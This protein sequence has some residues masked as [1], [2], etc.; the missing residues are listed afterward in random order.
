MAV[1]DLNDRKA[2]LEALDE[3]DRVG[4]D[5]FL[6]RHGFGRARDY[7][8]QHEGRLYDSK[9]IVGVAHGYQFGTP[10]GADA[11]SGGDAV[12]VPILERLG[13]PV[14]STRPKPG[15]W[16]DSARDVRVPKAVAETEWA[17]AAYPILEEVASRYGAVIYYKD[18]AE[19]I[20]DVSGVR[21]T[22]LLSN[23][24]GAVL[25]K[26]LHRAADEG[27]PPLTALVVRSEDGGVGDGYDESLFRYRGRRAGG[28]EERER[29][30]AED[31]LECY[32]HYA[33]DVPADAEPRLTAQLEKRL[34][35]KALPVMR[36]PAVCPSCFMQ[37]PVSGQ[38]DACA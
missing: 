28:R 9:A 4:R 36:P 16:R 26:T 33:D 1:T 6:E 12:V 19:R 37:L 27:K 35:T 8:I 22:V 38:C 25:G 34:R 21:T 7:F 18:L 17:D 32:R 13:F 3:Y 5:T 24:I 31:R 15:I 14:T 29:L 30:A 20:Q 2:V 11:F 10:L 23:W